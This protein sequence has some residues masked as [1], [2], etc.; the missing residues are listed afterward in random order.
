MP[1]DRHD[2]M[3][4]A[5]RRIEREAESLRD[6]TVVDEHAARAAA[7]A[8]LVAVATALRT[9]ASSVA[10]SSPEERIAKGRAAFESGRYSEAEAELRAA[11]RLDASRAPALILLARTLL[12]N[13]GYERIGT[14]PVVRS[15]LD[16]ATMLAPN[17]DDLRAVLE[18][19]TS[20]ANG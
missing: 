13:P 16:R 11:V 4:G 8:I 2:V 18:E 1:N 3:I 12:A 10:P 17:D 6:A 19:V 5:L 9:V 15:L 7:T 20:R 14:L